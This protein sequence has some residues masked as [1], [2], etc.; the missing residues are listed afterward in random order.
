MKSGLVLVSA[1]LSLFWLAGS[2]QTPMARALLR[3][4]T[5]LADILYRL[6]VAELSGRALQKK[7]I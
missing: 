2:A 3:F 4:L 6:K 1:A 5:C 7:A